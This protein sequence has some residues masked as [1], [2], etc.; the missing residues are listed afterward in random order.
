M[1]SAAR[2]GSD[3]ELVGWPPSIT[4]SQLSSIA[5]KPVPG[6]LSGANSCSYSCLMRLSQRWRQACRRIVDKRSAG[7][8]GSHDKACRGVLAKQREI[9]RVR[10][11]THPQSSAGVVAVWHI[12]K[13]RIAAERDVRE[14]KQIL[15]GK[16][17]DLAAEPR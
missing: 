14:V 1:T 7:P 8:V 15:G 16:A 12:A 13:C 4:A 9:G 6:E 17:R 2:P 5:R 11:V 3:I 10:A